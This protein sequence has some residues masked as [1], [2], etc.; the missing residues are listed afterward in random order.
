MGDTTN[1]DTVI[2]RAAKRWEH[3]IHGDLPRAFNENNS[4]WFRNKI[5]GGKQYTAPVV[6]DVVIGYAIRF[7]DGPGG[8]LGQAGPIKFRGTSKS[9]RPYATISGIL[10]LDAADLQR[11]D[12]EDQEAIVTHEIGHILGIGGVSQHMCAP[13]CKS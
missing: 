11:Y 1:Y 9:Q 6:D 4:D 8:I 5:P 13:N 10:Y 2:A 12:S 3:V 7:L